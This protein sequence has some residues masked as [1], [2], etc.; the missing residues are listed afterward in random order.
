MSF[1]GRG[2]SISDKSLNPQWAVRH[3]LQVNMFF[4]QFFNIQTTFDINRHY[5]LA[6]ELELMY[7]Y[8]NC[9]KLNY[10]VRFCRG[11]LIYF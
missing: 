4:Y 3:H 5:L 8:A 9:A 1:P 10:Y 11:D 2:L 6:I 7:I